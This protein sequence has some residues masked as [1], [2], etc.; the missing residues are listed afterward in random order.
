MKKMLGWTMVA[1][2]SIGGLAACSSDKDS[3]STTKATTATADTTAAGSGE[4]S[5]NAAVDEFCA[6]A[7]ELAVKLKD[8][9]A[10]PTSANAAE[11]TA[12]ATKLS[13]DG[14][15]LVSANPNDAAKIQ[16]CV[17]KITDAATPGG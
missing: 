1:V 16:E 9:I 14:A 4:S 7:D 8:V 6:Q 10:N 5:G 2:M 3:P 11:V 15:A 13:T 12:A 17:K